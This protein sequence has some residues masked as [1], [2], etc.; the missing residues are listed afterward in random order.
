MNR[1]NKGITLIALVVTIIVLL[2]L[3]GISISMISG[4]NG[5][6][7]K[8]GEAKIQTDFEKTKEELGLALTAASMEYH[9]GGIEG[10]LID[11]I[12]SQDGQNKIKRE[13][14]TNNVTFKKSSRTITYNGVKYTLASDG[15]ISSV[16][17][18]A[19][20]NTDDIE[21]EELPNDFWVASEGVAYINTKYITF[22]QDITYETYTDSYEV[23]YDWGTY[24][25]TYSGSREVMVPRPVG[26]CQYT[27]ILV[28]TNIDGETVTRFSVANV[29]NIVNLSISEGITELPDLTTICGTLE[30]MKIPK[31]INKTETELKSE[32][33]NIF[34]DEGEAYEIEDTK[35]GKFWLVTILGAT[36]IFIANGEEF[37][38]IKSN[39]I[40]FPAVIPTANLEDAMGH[41][42]QYDG[43]DFIGWYY[44]EEIRYPY[45]NV[46]YGRI[47]S[48]R[49][50]LWREDHEPHKAFEGD[51]ITDNEIT[52][53]ATFKGKRRC[54]FS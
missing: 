20:T 25:V 51:E 9:Q 47:Y 42:E 29:K 7:T 23:P 22:Q 3:A 27:K 34:G 48:S 39:K 45:N 31:T 43:Y 17:K 15:S 49:E 16:A 38:R 33:T 11:Y 24:T 21:A 2:I 46:D 8:A 12:F 52:L 13:L 37:A 44:D 5:I 4:Q 14:G 53:Y 36:I 41:I 35:D 40:K 30:E 50:T 54:M 1:S 28:P 32:L 6:L 26:D 10:T 18:I 19:V